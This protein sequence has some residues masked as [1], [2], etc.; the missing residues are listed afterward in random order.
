MRFTKI[1]TTIGPATCSVENLEKIAKMGISV[2]RLNFSHGDYA[3]HGQTIDNVKTVNKRGYS[4]AVMLDTKGP[5]VRTG[6][7]EKPIIVKKGDLV[8]FTS[9][10]TG[11][12]TMT[13]VKVDYPSFAEDVRNARCILIDNGSIEFTV[14]KIEKNGVVI[15]K[16]K[17]DGKIGSRR[18]VNLPGA[19]ISLPSFT[20][21]DWADIAFGVKKGV[22]FIATSFVRTGKDIRMLKAYLEKHKSDAEIIAKIETPEAVD[23]IDEIVASADGIMVARGDLGAEVPFEDVPMIQDELVEKCRAVGKPVIVATHMLESMIMSPMPT[24]AE[25]TDIA[26]AARSQADSTML[27]G[28]TTTGLYPFKAIDAMI[29]VLTKNEK[30]V[31][32]ISN[33]LALHSGPKK[34]DQDMPRSEQAIAASILATKLEADAIVVI[35]KS[36]KT[37]RAVSNCRALVPIHAFCGTESVQRKMML[38]WGVIPHAVTF[39]SDPEKTVKESI[40]SLLKSKQLKK[41]QRIVLVSDMRSS[42]IPVMTIQIRTLE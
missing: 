33:V 42:G 40:A 8:A 11:K 36:G 22:D 17:E 29:R 28:E 24:R 41:G 27:S 37:A 23:N 6:D 38:V 2:C 18:H 19:H 31:P 10:P 13:T 14:V 7:V 20:D 1:V 34:I 9:K 32:A 30:N 12:E 4:M 5:E 35:S 15:G 26:Y 39:H 3:V 21:K 16:S 25:V